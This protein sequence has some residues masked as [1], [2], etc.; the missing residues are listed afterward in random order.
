MPQSKRDLTV[1]CC[2]IRY[3]SPSSAL[4]GAVV[5]VGVL[6]I[7]IVTVMTI[8][9]MGLGIPSVLVTL[10]IYLWCSFV[11]DEQVV[12]L[13]VNVIILKIRSGI[14]SRNSVLE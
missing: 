6:K 4:K 5:Q 3:T 13:I 12:V 11:G 14:K 8:M 1:Q 2:P 9:I 7:V 10:C